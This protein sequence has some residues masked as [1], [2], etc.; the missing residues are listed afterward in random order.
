MVKNEVYEKFHFVARK[1]LDTYITYI[2]TF[3]IFYFIKN[4]Y[5]LL[6][7]LYIRKKKKEH[8]YTH[9]HIRCIPFNEN[10][11]ETKMHSNTIHRKNSVSIH[12][13]VYS[14]CD[15]VSFYFIQTINKEIVPAQPAVIAVC[16]KI[17]CTNSTAKKIWREKLKTF[18]IHCGQHRIHIRAYSLEAMEC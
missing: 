8:K 18:E 16:G 15:Q 14:L 17:L 6:Y 11:N 13:I 5:C 7:F 4:F 1:N 2:H 10:K 3:C 12:F 9:T